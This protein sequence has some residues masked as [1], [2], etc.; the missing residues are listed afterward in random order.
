MKPQIL[1]TVFLSMVCLPTL[2]GVLVQRQRINGLQEEH[3]KL[4]AE[5]AKPS[6]PAEPP[7]TVVS[8]P[9]PP[10]EL[11][12]LRAEVTS[13]MR[14]KRELAGVRTENEQL[15]DQ[16][17]AKAARESETPVLPEGYVPLSKAQF[18]GYSTPHDTVESFL[19]TL[20]I[21]DF[22]NFL[23]TLTPEAARKFSAEVQGDADNMQRFTKLADEVPGM[24]VVGSEVQPDG[25]IVLK[26][27]FVPGLSDVKVPLRQVGGEWKIDL[28]FY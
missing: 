9:S 2:L 20:R 8:R 4:Q 3:Q 14:H 7:E 28:N 23:Q 25:S 15:H 22:Q 18:R 17:A 21:H 1:L 10:V 13:L 19:W 16:L 24:R 12:Q 11:L 27:D 5:A 26:V 6:A